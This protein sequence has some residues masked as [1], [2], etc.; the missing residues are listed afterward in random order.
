MLLASKAKR[1]NWAKDLPISRTLDPFPHFFCP[2]FPILPAIYHFYGGNEGWRKRGIAMGTWEDRHFFPLTSLQIGDLQSY[3]SHW[4]LFLATRSKKFFILVDNRPWLI[5][6]N[7]RAAHLWQ[8]MVTKSRLSPFANTRATKVARRD[9]GKILEFTN[10]SRSLSINR[11]RSRKWF[12]LI[13]AA[14]SQKK[15]LLHVK[16]LKN[17]FLLNKE[18]HCPVYGFIVFEVEWDH[19]RGINYINELQTDTSLA[20]EVK[21]M[22][23]WEF[24]S[25]EQASSYISSWYTG[26]S[27]E[28][29]LLQ[30][31]LESISNKGEVFYDAQEDI[32]TSS[33]ASENLPTNNELHEEKHIFTFPHSIQSLE[34]V[35]YSDSPFTPPACGPY[36]RRKIIKSSGGSDIDEVSEE[37]YS[38]IVSSP[39]TSVSSASLSSCESDNVSLIFEA[40]TYRDV[41]ILFR[42]DD[43]DLPFKLKEIIMSDLRLLTLLEYGLPSWVIF[44][45]S[46]PVFCQIYR[47]WMCP[48]ARAL[49][50]LISITTVLIGF[51]DLYK[52]VPVL[53]ATASSLFGPLFDWIESWEM[54]SRVRYLGTMLFLHNFEKAL[55][56]FLM[57]ARATKSFLSVFTKPIAGPVM[58]LFE[59]IFP[60]WNICFDA[61]ESLSLVICNVLSSSCSMITSLLEVIVWPFWY[62]FSTLWSIAAYVIYPVVWLLLKIFVAPIRLILAIASFIGMI[63]TNIYYL[64]RETWTSIGA[65]F[66]LASGLTVDN[67]EVSLWRSRWKDLFTKVFRAIRSIFYGIIAFFTACNRHRLSIYNHILEFLHRLSHVT[68]TSRLSKFEEDR[69]KGKNQNLLQERQRS[70]SNSSFQ[71]PDT[72][73]RLHRRRV[74]RI[75]SEN[76][77]PQSV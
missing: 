55:K 57:V 26:N 27:N 63:F 31:Y 32:S 69:K 11:N 50:V 53:K 47:P 67:P 3:L 35:E 1:G 52:N 42:F 13:D 10:S 16:K 24:D 49:Y 64:L 20:M 30:E 59:F 43:H 48:L 73:D 37:P 9:I 60:I 29:F 8:L 36:K 23:R 25:I 62:I 12:S 40:T 7:L 22:K 17:S 61:V 15:K 34:G 5:D 58:E 6:Q 4:T 66:Q 28:C 19:V 51:Y 74:R 39:T 71:T 33:E 18:L 44:L 14:L 41:L 56:W 2:L 45:Q 54:I 38:E 72:A 21:L 77:A 70:T 46:Y 75:S 76:I 65:L 68:H